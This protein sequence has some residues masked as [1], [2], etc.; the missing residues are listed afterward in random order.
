M[1]SS[2]RSSIPTRTAIFVFRLQPVG[3]RI[4]TL[5]T[6]VEFSSLLARNDGVLQAKLGR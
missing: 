5:L 3:Q 1:Y 6:T 2:L 4:D